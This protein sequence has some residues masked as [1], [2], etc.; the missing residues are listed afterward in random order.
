MT[1][2]IFGVFR[3][4]KSDEYLRLE[5]RKNDVHHFYTSQKSSGRVIESSTTFRLYNENP[6]STWGVNDYPLRQSVVAS[7]GTPLLKPVTVKMRT[8][9]TF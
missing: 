6:W 9:T 2:G 1:C 5:F 3:C 8:F 7:L 4:K